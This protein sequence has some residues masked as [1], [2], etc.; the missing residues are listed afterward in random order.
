M[1]KVEL[2]F[3]DGDTEHGTD[4]PGIT[5]FL[6]GVEPPLPLKNGDLDV[7]VATPAQQAAR[8]ALEEVAGLAATKQILSLDESEMQ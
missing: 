3:E 4:Q 8:L 2:V 6:R 1:A 7:D 5:I